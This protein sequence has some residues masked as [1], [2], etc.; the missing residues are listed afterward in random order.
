MLDTHGRLFSRWN[1]IDAAAL[2]AVAIVILLGYGTW[3]AFRTPTP[4]VAS[5]SPVQ[6][7]ADRPETLSISGEHLRP[8]LSVR[9]GSFT[10]PLLAESPARAEV[11]VTG[12][13]PGS[14][15]LALF[16]EA[17]ELVR[18]RRALTVVAPLPPEPPPQMQ[19][20]IEGAFVSVPVQ[21]AARV[22][23]GS[24][25][26]EASAGSQAA[27]GEVLATL[28]PEIDTQRLRVS[29]SS[30]M[31]MPVPDRVRVR[32]ILRLRCVVVSERCRLGNIDVLKDA[33]VPLAM[34]SSAA[35]T[36]TPPDTHLL[37]RV[38]EFRPAMAP[39]NFQSRAFMAQG[40]PQHMEVEVQGV[41]AF[42]ALTAQDAARIRVGIHFDEEVQSAG[43]PADIRSGAR[44]PVGEVLAVLPP[45]PSTQRLRVGD[46]SAMTAPVADKRQVPAI[47]RLRCVVA[48]DR[49]RISGVDIARDA[50]VPLSLPVPSAALARVNK[51]YVFR[52]DEVRPV[53]AAPTF[54][55]SARFISME[56]NAVGDFIHLSREDA[57]RIKTGSHFERPEPAPGRRGTDEG[58][59]VATVLAARAPETGTLQV[60]VGG[61]PSAIISSRVPNTW[62]VPAIVRLRC[63]ITSDQCRIGEVNVSEGAIVPLA[64]PVAAGESFVRPERIALFRI[65]RAGPADTPI[66]FP[67]TRTADA[68]LRVRFLVKPEV[69]GLPMAGDKD[70]SVPVIEDA[71]DTQERR[72]ALIE[73]DTE[74]QNVVA[75]TQVER[76][77]F[78]ETMAT[79]E[80]R[81]RVPVVLTSTGWQYAGR[82][83]KVGA[84]FKF[85]GR[86]YAMD[87]W[88]LAI[89]VGHE[90]QSIA[91]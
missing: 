35:K 76:T 89:E 84:P 11:K 44:A 38:D 59:T 39:L 82:P 50:L 91:R 61:S 24:T 80:A 73:V 37:F 16:D 69:A 19:V 62:Q 29:D 5:I 55:S 46:A 86:T 26:S 34:S 65:K 54:E 1:I 51:Q 20:E 58:V 4:I 81:L 71:E 41:G 67:T 23:P 43:A 27:V 42:L 3:L 88:V 64:T 74:P 6:I 15:D 53:T 9:L 60:R 25:F 2:A 48:V 12:L 8:F 77:A 14:Y 30:V 87:G 79:F 70:S 68:V 31:T 72:A 56:M 57:G 17:R 22:R 66:D 18:V 32:A 45:E 33:L 63:I 52:I 85:E 90:T 78:Q 21:D 49:C 28:P 36:L 47:V 75:T 10:A 40:S 83:V 13:S 7:T